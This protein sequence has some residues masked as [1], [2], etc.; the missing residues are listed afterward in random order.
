MDDSDGFQTRVLDTVLDELTSNPV[1][2]VPRPRWVRE[3][4]R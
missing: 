1:G 3:S 2:L 4:L